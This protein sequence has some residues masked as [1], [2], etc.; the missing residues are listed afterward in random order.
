MSVSFY[1]V[2]ER[3]WFCRTGRRYDSIA[4]RAYGIVELND[5]APIFPLPGGHTVL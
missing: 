4:R 2:A 5:I 3:K 1:F